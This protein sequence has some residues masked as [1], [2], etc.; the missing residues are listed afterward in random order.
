MAKLRYLLIL[1]T[2]VLISL[3]GC[4]NNHFAIRL[5]EIFTIGVGDS[6]TARLL[7][8][9]QAVEQDYSKPLSTS[10]FTEYKL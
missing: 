3:T 4:S 5:G 7:V 6:V 8:R 1:V 9:D 10:L 2:I